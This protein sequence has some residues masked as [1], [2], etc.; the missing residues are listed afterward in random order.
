MPALLI[1]FLSPILT[2][3]RLRTA[4][5]LAIVLTVA[6]GWFMVGI[7]AEG[8]AYREATDLLRGDGIK[9]EELKLTDSLYQRVDRI[10]TQRSMQLAAANRPLHIPIGIITA[11]ILASLGWGLRKLI[12]GR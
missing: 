12:R 1:A 8:Q 5:V 4:I 11:V 3:I 6:V 7:L 9:I 10:I 2:L